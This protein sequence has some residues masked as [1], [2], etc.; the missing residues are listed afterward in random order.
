MLLFASFH[1]K[2]RILNSSEGL[3]SLFSWN[4]LMSYHVFN[5]FFIAFSSFTR[6]RIHIL[7]HSSCKSICI[8]IKL[9]LYHLYISFCFCSARQDCNT[10]QS[11]SKR[12][13]S[14]SI[15]IFTYPH[16]NYS[17]LPDY[18]HEYD[19]KRYL[20]SYWCIPCHLFIHH[21]PLV[22]RLEISIN[23]VYALYI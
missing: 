22:Y 3:S 20:L 23:G 1:V 2:L 13:R 17:N 16:F 6:V 7:L 15:N 12:S 21:K 18:Y 19:T 14:S 4:S 8:S 9:K 11:M 10:F 5:V